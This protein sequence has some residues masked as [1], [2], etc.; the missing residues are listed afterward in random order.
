MG[1]R[2]GTTDCGTINKVG[3]YDV[4]CRV[5]GVCCAISVFSN[6]SGIVPRAVP[7]SRQDR[8]PPANRVLELYD[9]HS[10]LFID[11]L[12][13]SPDAAD[14]PGQT[15]DR[16]ALLGLARFRGDGG[17]LSDETAITLIFRMT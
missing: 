3:E 15:T 6:V 16:S 14:R 7:P 17:E 8:S 2:G 5:N 4:I 1:E 13:T 10:V 12:S 9:F 11:V